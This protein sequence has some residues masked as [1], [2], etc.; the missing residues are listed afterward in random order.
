MAPTKPHKPSKFVTVTTNSEPAY[1][2]ERLA[3]VLKASRDQAL[4]K[5]RPDLAAA[6]MDLHQQSLTDKRLRSLLCAIYRSTAT[7]RQKRE[8]QDHLDSAKRCY[9]MIQAASQLQLQD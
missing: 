7:P 8:F 4:Q 9:T 2:P 5:G 3:Q 6:I 1:T